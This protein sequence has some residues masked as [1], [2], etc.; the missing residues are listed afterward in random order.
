MFKCR[1]PV[2]NFIEKGGGL[3]DLRGL[4]RSCLSLTNNLIALIKK[5]EIHMKRMMLPLVGLLLLTTGCFSNHLINEELYNEYLTRT[6]NYSKQKTFDATLA[7]LKE[8][9]TGVEK[10]DREKG[11]ITTKKVEFFRLVQV[12]GN[13]YSATGQTFS[14]THKYYL[15]ITGD[16]K[17]ATVKAIR[18]R[19]WK[20]AV[21]QPDLNA[22]WTK[23]NV[24]DPFFNLIQE[25]LEEK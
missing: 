25:K 20:N 19:L 3:F 23:E 13:Q 9:Q 11:L 17:S 12:T 10:Q 14:A 7:A 6:Y 18:Y 1:T 2:N 15:Q 22:S 4:T 5:K 24:W 16:N 8:L 21:E